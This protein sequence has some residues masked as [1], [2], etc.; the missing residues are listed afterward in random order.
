MQESASS[1]MLVGKVT[2]LTKGWASSWRTVLPRRLRRSGAHLGLLVGQWA[3][4]WVVVHLMQ[5]AD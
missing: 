3:G 4:G 2:T 1:M 5:Y